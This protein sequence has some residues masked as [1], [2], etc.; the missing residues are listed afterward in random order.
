MG[1]MDENPANKKVVSVMYLSLGEAARKQFKDDYPHTR[2]WNLTIEALITMCNECFLEKKNEI[3][4][5]TA[6]TFSPECNNLENRFTNFGT[7]LTDWQFH[8]TLIE[9]PRHWY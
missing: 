9:L 6:M 7:L 1:D 5:Y 4:R 2:L 3:E 8:T